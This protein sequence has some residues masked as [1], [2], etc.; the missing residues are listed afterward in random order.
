MATIGSHYFDACL[1][2]AE[3]RG[4]KREEFLRRAGIDP[5]YISQPQ[6]RGGIERMAMMVRDIW[7]K[8]DDEFMGFTEHPVRFGAFAI[9]TEMMLNSGTVLKALERGLSFYRILTGDITTILALE[10][11]DVLLTAAPRRP[12]LDPDHYFIEF[13]LVIWHRMACWLANE[14]VPL[15]SASFAY[16]RP[17]TYSDE[18]R[19]LFPC[20]HFFDRPVCALRMDGKALH[21]PV[22][23]TSAELEIMVG[24]APLDIMTIPAS[25]HSISRKLRLVLTPAAGTP[26]HTLSIA[27]AAARL[28]MSGTVLA[29]RL[30]REGTTYGATLQAIRR[31]LAIGRLRRSQMTVEQIATELG[32]EETRSFTRAF[33]AWT[34]ESPLRFRRG[35]AGG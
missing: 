9:M 27:D 23:R 32:F 11:Q 25:D 5:A 28:G 16:P 14:A 7:I 12:E 10:G 6:A 30:R 2:G 15:R 24:Q 21:G 8:L 18:L 22:V 17:A 4:H 34:G 20:T 35:A 26:F 29:R 19:Y 1:R 33:H 3:R 31:D 13:W